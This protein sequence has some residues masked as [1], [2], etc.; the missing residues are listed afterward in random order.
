MCEGERDA[1][2]QRGRGARHA[3]TRAEHIKVRGMQGSGGQPAF[4]PLCIFSAS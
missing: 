3:Q 4:A 1:G 2:E